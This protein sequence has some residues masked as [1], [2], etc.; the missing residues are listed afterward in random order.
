M[1]TPCRPQPSCL[2]RLKMAR[3][4]D[5]LVWLVLALVGLCYYQNTVLSKR[6]AVIYYQNQQIEKFLQDGVCP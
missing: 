2:G 5:W 1:W 4:N 6:V 3:F